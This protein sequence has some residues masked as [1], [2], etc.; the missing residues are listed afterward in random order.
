M[1]VFSIEA[2]ARE[3]NTV[4]VFLIHRSDKKDSD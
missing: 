2:S 3:V 4:A 1:W